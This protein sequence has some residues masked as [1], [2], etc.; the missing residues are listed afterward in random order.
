MQLRPRSRSFSESR[1][2][3]DPNNNNTS[4]DTDRSLDRHQTDDSSIKAAPSETNR[5]TPGSYYRDRRYVS[6]SC[7]EYH[8]PRRGI[9]KNYRINLRRTMS[10]SNTDNY[11]EEETDASYPDLSSGDSQDSGDD[12]PKKSV[13]FNDRTFTL[14][15]RTGSSILGRKQHNKKKNKRRALRRLNSTNS[16]SSS[17]L[18]EAG[19]DANPSNLG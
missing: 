14:T 11:V 10:E 6:E 2:N 1:E 16:H 17:S 18:D 3:D 9:L 13:H 7:D 19:D 4:T 5:P 15:F 12:K 8:G